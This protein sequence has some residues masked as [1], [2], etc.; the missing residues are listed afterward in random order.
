MLQRGF[1]AARTFYV[2]HDRADPDDDV[3]TLI[4]A[5]QRAN[6]YPDWKEIVRHPP[7]Y[8]RSHDEEDIGIRRLQGSP[9]NATSHYQ[10]RGLQETANA[11]K[12]RLALACNRNY[13][14]Y[15]GGTRADAMAAMVSLMARVNG[16]FL[17]EAAVFFEIV[18]PTSDPRGLICVGT[19][20][21][22]CDT[23]SELS[24]SDTEAMVG[25]GQ[26]DTFYASR[27][28][29]SDDYDVGHMLTTINGGRALIG[30][31]CQTEKNEAVS[32]L[33]MPDSDE[34]AVSLV[35]H[36]IGHQLDAEHT[37]RDCPGQNDQLDTTEGVEPGSG[38][39][40]MSY[41]GLCGAN[42]LQ[43]QS[44]AFFNS[45][46]L[47]RIRNLVSGR[48]ESFANCGEMVEMTGV[49]VPEVVRLADQTVPKGN[50]VKL[51]S[52]VTNIASY[53]NG[54]Y[55]AWDRVN[56]GEKTFTDV[57]IPR[58]APRFPKFNN[59]DRFLPNMYILSFGT[60]HLSPPT[61]LEEIEPKASVAGSET[62]DFR[63]SAR[64]M[65]NTSASATVD[66]FDIS[67]AGAFG[68][69]KLLYCSEHHDK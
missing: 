45:I 18:I 68:W 15:F 22:D 2:D 67:L 59:L 30:T 52:T 63:F 34:F 41:A 51:G 40:I 21:T 55:Y 44:D 47:V 14:E 17:R 16:I 57:N 8:V 3:L 53:P 27:S 49:E 5:G 58:F 42:D 9:S 56:G 31:L 43:G 62:L 46:S 69:T 35:A 6:P 23:D 25:S 29:V 48:V 54:L 13:T 20:D 19:E 36:E 10:H 50:Y 11:Y 60:D 33:P 64:T 28:V 66:S 39:T 7:D 24:F 32:G 38:S 1:G 4:Q 61:S 65:F 26:I 37:F 12:L